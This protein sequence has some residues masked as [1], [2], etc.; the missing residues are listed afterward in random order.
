VF[1]E[2]WN[3][4]PERRILVNGKP[5]VDIVDGIVKA[6]LSLIYGGMDVDDLLGKALHNPLWGKHL[7][8]IGD[9]L[10]TYPDG[11]VSYAG[12]IAQRNNMKLTHNGRSGEKLCKDISGNPAC[13]NSYTNDIP[14][15]ADYI[16]CQIGANDSD[17]WDPTVPDDNMSTTTF[18]GCW[19]QLL[20]GLKRH[21]PNARIGMI[22]ANSWTYN[23]GQ[24]SEDAIPNTDLRKR[25]QWQKI[26][27]QK[28]NVPIFDPLEDTRF[29][30][31]DFKSY[32]T[33]DVVTST[34]I[35]DSTLDW[36]DMMKRKMGTAN[37]YFTPFGKKWY[38]QTPYFTDSW[39]TTE[40]G[41]RTLS[42]FYEKWMKTVLTSN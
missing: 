35:P 37:L 27:A 29:I 39:H 21:Y 12:C 2:N 30:T 6:K 19:N 3:N 5:L 14:P 31:W 1:A 10:I 33:N 8:A 18:K 24:R 23:I 9:S 16:L 20:I 13:I 22:V 7:A 36:Y 25:T 11:Y 38:S 15:D 4:Q 17:S 32:A 41:H 26:Q 34:Y 28:L 42:F 40:K